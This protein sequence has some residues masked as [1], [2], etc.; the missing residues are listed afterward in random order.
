MLLLALQL[1]CRIDFGACWIMLNKKSKYCVFSIIYTVLDIVLLKLI[2]P[3]F[4]PQPVYDAPAALR[5]SKKD[6]T[7]HRFHRWGAQ[8]ACIC[9]GSWSCFSIIFYWTH[10]FALYFATFVKASLGIFIQIDALRARSSDPLRLGGGNQEVPTESQD[11]LKLCYGHVMSCPFWHLH[12]YC[13]CTVYIYIH[14]Y[15][16]IHVYT[17][18]IIMYYTDSDSWPRM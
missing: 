9:F 8:A 13:I 15:I 14:T 6:G 5:A 16:Y 10:W 18:I 4:F 17:Y 2:L 3:R 11:P 12:L 1:C 7:M